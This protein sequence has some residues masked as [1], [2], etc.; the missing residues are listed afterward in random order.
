MGYISMFKAMSKA[1]Q[2]QQQKQQ[3]QAGQGRMQ[4][5]LAINGQ[6]SGP[7]TKTE[8]EQLVKNG[9][10]TA[11]TYVWETGM[12]NWVPAAT[13]P[14]VNKLLVLYAPKRAKGDGLRVTGEKK[15]HPL[16][17]DLI[18]A[19]SNLGIKGAEMNSAIDA[20]LA[21]QPQIELSQAVKILLQ[22]R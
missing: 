2:P 11:E 4:L 7:Y 9:T 16:R 21:A 20:L 15:E 6:Q 18:S 17:Q 10:L 14:H 22:K 13:L 19:M 3:K 5:Y 12:A 1:M 8:A